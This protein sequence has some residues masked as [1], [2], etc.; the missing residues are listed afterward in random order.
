MATCCGSLGRWFNSVSYQV[1]ALPA[2]K[3]V[4]LIG[5]SQ[6]YYKLRKEYDPQAGS[7][8]TTPKKRKASDDDEDEEKK[9]TPSKRARE[10]PRDPTIDG[11]R[12]TEATDGPQ[13]LKT[14]EMAASVWD[15]F[16]SSHAQ[17]APEAFNAAA[18]MEDQMYGHFHHGQ[19]SGSSSFI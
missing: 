19:S 6:K 9:P 2:P 8:P 13:E 3:L 12:F 16:Q 15:S 7:P 4:T 18:G 17:F 14:E 10:A 1:R 5:N 11:V